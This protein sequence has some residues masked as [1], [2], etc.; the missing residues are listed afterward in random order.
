MDRIEIDNVELSEANIAVKYWLSGGDDFQYLIFRISDFEHWLRVERK[1]SIQKYWDHWDQAADEE[2]GTAIIHQDVKQFL[3]N[4]LSQGLA[5]TRLPL[6]KV[7]KKP[8]SRVSG[9]STDV[10]SESA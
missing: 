2:L 8:M 3:A 6:T 7:N 5:S 1:I 9:T 4:K 10:G